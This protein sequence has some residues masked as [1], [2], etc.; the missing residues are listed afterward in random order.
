VCDDTCG[1]GLYQYE[2][3]TGARPDTLLARERD[4][5]FNAG[6]VWYSGQSPILRKMVRAFS[7]AMDDP[8]RWAMCRNDQYMLRNFVA[9]YSD[10]IDIKRFDGQ[11]WNPIGKC[12]DDLEQRGQHWVNRRTGK[13]QFIWH[14]CGSGVPWE[15][16]S[17]GGVSSDSVRKAFSWASERV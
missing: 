8:F 14:A 7:E 9:L 4:F 5:Q 17:R 2:T 15:S 13:V 11:H 3:T 16:P 10:Q 6:I 12:A 1:P